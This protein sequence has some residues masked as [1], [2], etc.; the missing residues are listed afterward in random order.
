MLYTDLVKAKSEVLVGS[1]KNC[2]S[3][4]KFSEPAITWNALIGQ[5][6]IL[7][8]S[9]TPEPAIQSYNTGQPV[10]Y[11]GSCQLIIT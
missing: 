8:T 9:C 4:R 5:L 2:L 7:K 6:R 11:F 1:F 3:K 10:S